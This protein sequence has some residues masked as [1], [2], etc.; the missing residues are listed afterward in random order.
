[1][2]NYDIEVTDTFGGDANYCWVHRYHVT[3]KSILGAI[4]KLSRLEG[5]S[6][7]KD[8]GDDMSARYNVP[9]ACICAFITY[10]EG[11]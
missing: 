10:S 2:N 7:R 5:L 9:G 3:A 4:Q 6:F 8:Y 11:V 1:M